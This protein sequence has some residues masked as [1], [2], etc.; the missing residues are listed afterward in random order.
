MWFGVTSARVAGGSSS[1]TKGSLAVCGGPRA[2]LWGG[3]SKLPEALCE[4]SGVC[5]RCGLGRV[6]HTAE[7]LASPGGGGGG[8]PRGTA[9]PPRRGRPPGGAA[10]PPPPEARGGGSREVHQPRHGRNLGEG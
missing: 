10:P 8:G 1:N 7:P 2:H 5:L 6:V 4:K 3:E 9:P